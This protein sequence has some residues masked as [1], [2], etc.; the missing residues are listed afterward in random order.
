MAPITVLLTLLAILGCAGGGFGLSPQK[1]DVFIDAV[2]GREWRMA[3]MEMEG[4]AFATIADSLV[5][6]ACTPDGEV[7]GTASINRYAGRL[8]VEGDRILR[9]GPMR[10]TRMAG[11][12]ELMTQEN[13]YLEA[14]TQTDR[15]YLYGEKLILENR[16][17]GVRL[18][19]GRPTD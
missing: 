18:E 16:K 12:P 3:R 15:L 2:A 7:S 4:K 14:L 11:P 1:P 5:T 8:T 13:R 10:T 19:F 6:F 17:K 9:W